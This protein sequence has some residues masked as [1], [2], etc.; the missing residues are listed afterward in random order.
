M[1]IGTGNYT[2]TDK[3]PGCTRTYDTETAV[4][5]HR[6]TEHVSLLP[7]FMGFLIACTFFRWPVAEHVARSWTTMKSGPMV[8]SSRPSRYSPLAI[9]AAGLLSLIAATCYRT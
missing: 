5:D 3:V 6:L 8:P 7:A 4:G 1:P 2:G 9:S